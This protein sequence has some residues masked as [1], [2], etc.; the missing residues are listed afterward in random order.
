MWLASHHKISKNFLLNN[1]KNLDKNSDFV[2]SM[3]LDYFKGDSFNQK[4]KQKFSFEHN[5]YKNIRI[6]FKYCWKTHGLFYSLIR[7]DVLINASKSLKSYLAADWMFMINLIAKGKVCRTKDTYI[8]LGKEGNSS[9]K[10]LS[11]Y[12]DKKYYSIL[13]YFYF[14]KNFYK[15][16]NKSN[17]LNFFQ[18]YILSFLSLCL[19][20]RYLISIIRK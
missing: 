15:F 17:K 20:I 3:G 12:V 4:N 9:K 11:V 8:V 18:K 16:I 13:P 14:N 2:A 7:K 1:S 10:N 19:N 5:V 6:F